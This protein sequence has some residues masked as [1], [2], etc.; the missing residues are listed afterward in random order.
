MNK[1]VYLLMGALLAFPLAVS[2]QTVEVQQQTAPAP[3]VTVAPPANTAATAPVVVVPPSTTSTVVVPVPV[4][5]QAAPV[6]EQKLFLRDA[7]TGEYVDGPEVKEREQTLRDRV[8]A[9][10]KE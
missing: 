2:A 10:M 5:N 3:A 6:V 9:K 4:T 1:Q 8:R 7:I